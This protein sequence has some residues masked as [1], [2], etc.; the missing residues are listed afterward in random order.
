MKK[1]LAYSIIPAIIGIGAL[2]VSFASAHGGFGFGGFSGEIDPAQI[3]ERQQGMFQH[4]ADLLGISVDEIKNAWAE[5]KN[6]RQL[7]EEKGLTEQLWEKMKA[8]REVQIKSRFQALIDGGIITQEQADS[9][10]QAMENFKFRERKE[11][12]NF[13]PCR[14]KFSEI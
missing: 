2:G 4:E 5:G 8:E 3:A 12:K 9:R 6:A 1:I 10:F 13:D 14:Q 7:A 11:M